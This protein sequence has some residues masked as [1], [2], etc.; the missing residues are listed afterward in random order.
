[1]PCKD[2]DALREVR[3]PQS[4]LSGACSV[5]VGDP[6]S[7]LWFGFPKLFGRDTSFFPSLRP[8]PQPSQVL[9]FRIR[10]GVKGLG[11]TVKISGSNPAWSE[12]G[13]SLYYRW[14][15]ASVSW[16]QASL[17][18]GIQGTPLRLAE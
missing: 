1:M 16:Y 4:S 6:F 5:N 2:A 15:Y 7:F 12:D 9:E 10:C 14:F 3:R 18:S 13:T 11:W 17:G 8:T